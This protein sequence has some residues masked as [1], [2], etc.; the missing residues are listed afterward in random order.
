MYTIFVVA[1]WIVIL[2]IFGRKEWA[3]LG[4]VMCLPFFIIGGVIIDLFAVFIHF[5]P[6]GFLALTH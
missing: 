3:G 6:Y 4:V 2:L 5:W 1:L